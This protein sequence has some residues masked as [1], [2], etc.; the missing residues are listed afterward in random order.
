V[1]KHSRKPAFLRRRTLAKWL[2]DLQGDAALIYGATSALLFAGPIKSLQLPGICLLSPGEACPRLPALITPL[3]YRLTEGDGNIILPPILA[4]TAGEPVD[5]REMATPPRTPVLGIYERIEAAEPLVPV[6]DALAALP[7]HYLW[8]GGE[9]PG[10]AGLHDYSRQQGLE[11]RVRFCGETIERDAFLKSIDTLLIPPG[12]AGNAMIIPQAWAHGTPVISAM[13]TDDNPVRD[14]ESGLN[15][16]TNTPKNWQDAI[17][18]ITGEETAFAKAL[19]KG[20]LSAYNAHFRP[21]QFAE[22]LAQ[23]FFAQKTSQ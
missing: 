10:L 9:G 16:E 18:R 5:P 17:Q 13:N 11:K 12:D 14:G 2:K 15:L 1:P 22:T 23:N 4:Q 8:V 3:H 19:T 20:G 21:E 6:L 7:G